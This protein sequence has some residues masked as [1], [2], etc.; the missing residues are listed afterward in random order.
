MKLSGHHRKPPDQ[1]TLQI[2]KMRAAF[3]GITKKTSNFSA[4]P[5][6]TFEIGH[7]F[8]LTELRPVTET[9]KL[10]LEVAGECAILFGHS[11]QKLICLKKCTA[12]KTRCAIDVKIRSYLRVCSFRHYDDSTPLTFPD[13]DLT[14]SADLERTHQK[15]DKCGRNERHDWACIRGGKSFVAFFLFAL[16]LWLTKNINLHRECSTRLSK[17]KSDRWQVS[18]L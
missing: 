16:F 10:Y 17:R 18:S 15:R 2:C 3:Q 4:Y 11:F 14:S 1:P 9:E 13:V 12:V 6:F 5:R 7:T 8:A